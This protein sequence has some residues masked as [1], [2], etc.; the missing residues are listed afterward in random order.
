MN[1][2]DL[3]RTALKKIRDD[4]WI[5]IQLTAPGGVVY[6]FAKGTDDELLLGDVRKESNEFDPE[7][8]GKIAVKKLSITIRIDDLTR[9]PTENEEW[10]I[11][12][13]DN[14]LNHDYTFVKAAFNSDNVDVGGDS[15]GW[16][17]IFPQETK[18]V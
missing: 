18:L 17:K 8:G 10:F 16:I 11:E 6:E 9:I 15:Q 4:W 13:P 1:A 7:L 5:P 3:Q 12:Y 2:L 14:L